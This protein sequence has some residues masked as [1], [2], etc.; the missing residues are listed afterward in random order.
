MLI[1][2]NKN[3]DYSSYECK[4][5]EKMLKKYYNTILITQFKTKGIKKRELRA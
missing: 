2:V 4:S 5:L 3:F 1:Q